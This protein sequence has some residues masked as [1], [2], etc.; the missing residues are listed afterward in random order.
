MRLTSILRCV[1]K[2]PKDYPNLP[3]SY[4]KRSMA[5]VEWRTPNKPQYQRK[6]IERK[7]FYYNT[8]RPW[9]DEFKRANAP[10]LRRRKIHVQ[11]IDWHVFR[12]DRVEVLVGKDKG[13]QGIV[14]YIV[15]ERNWVMVEG[16]N[17]FYRHIKNQGKVQVMKCEAPLLVTTQI[18]LLDPTDNK[19][20]QIEWRYTEE[21]K[22]VRVSVRSGRILPIPLAA[23]ETYDYKSKG[24]YAGK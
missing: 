15:K 6:V 2:L 11:P 4:V 24:A 19:P 10:G 14:N 7:E 20:T 21:G 13:K 3:E 18:A 5:Q 9:T 8:A 12:G 17:C 16:L 22:K 1:S 23:E